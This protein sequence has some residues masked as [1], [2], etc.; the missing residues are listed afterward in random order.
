MPDT[1]DR[2][3]ERYD[4]AAADRMVA[5]TEGMTGIPQLTGL[6]IVRFAPGRLWAQADLG[7]DFV[8]PSGNVHGGAVAAVLDHITGAVVYPLMPDGWWGATI[9]LKLN[10][11]APVRAGLLEADATVLSVGNRSAVVR[12]EA[13]CADRLVCAAQGTIALVAP[14]ASK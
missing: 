14:R 3:A 6:R 8:T 10:Y 2:F 5:A 13:F 7:E 1:L 9:E 12:G 4:A 11:I